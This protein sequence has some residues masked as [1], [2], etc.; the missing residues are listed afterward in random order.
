[1]FLPLYDR[2][3]IKKDIATARTK[4]G[5]L[6]PATAQET[7]TTGVVMAVGAGRI[8]DTGER[9]EPLV[10]LYDHVM[11]SKHAGTEIKLVGEEYLLLRESD[12]FGVLDA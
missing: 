3:L 2:V 9:V 7:V 11:F 6:I 12:I 4:S 1:V 10:K 5:L 8:T